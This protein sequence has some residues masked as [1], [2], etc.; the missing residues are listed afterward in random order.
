MRTKNEY[1]KKHFIVEWKA[2][3]RRKKLLY[4]Y[5]REKSNNFFLNSC[6]TSGIL[7]V[8]VFDKATTSLNILVLDSEEEVLL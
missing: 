7:L 1:K 3:Q 2:G 8:N 6:P 5:F 4:N